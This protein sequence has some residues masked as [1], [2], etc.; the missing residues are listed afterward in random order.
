MNACGG[1]QVLAHEPGTLCPGQYTGI[2]PET[3][4]DCA[5]DAEWECAGVNGVRC[6]CEC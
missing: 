6:H 1:S 3:G 4:I 5:R 2:C